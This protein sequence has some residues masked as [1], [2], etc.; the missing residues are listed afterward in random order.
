MIYVIAAELAAPE[1]GNAR[2][3]EWLGDNLE[4]MAEPLA[5]LWIA[6]GALAAEQIRNGLEPLLEAGDRLVVIKAMLEAVWL[7]LSPENAR[8]MAASF[9]G[10][11]TERIPNPDEGVGRR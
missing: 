7:G 4:R 10:S 11:I 9:P 8:W 3:A 5:G 2:I 1:L 6:E